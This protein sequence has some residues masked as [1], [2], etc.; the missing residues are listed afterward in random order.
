VLVGDG[1]EVLGRFNLVDVEDGSAELG[2][3]FPSMLRG[4]DWPPPPCAGSAGGPGERRPPAGQRPACELIGTAGESA[5]L[6]KITVLG[7]TPA[8]RPIGGRD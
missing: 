8:T 7:A 6:M 5:G 2:Y 3:R 1:G 4:R